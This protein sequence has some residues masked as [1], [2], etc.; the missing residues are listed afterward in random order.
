MEKKTKILIVD[1]DPDTLEVYAQIFGH[2]GY[3]VDVA[4]TAKEG[5]RLARECH[6]ALVLLDVILPDA[7]GI[8]VCQQIKSDPELAGT[9]VINLSAV[10]T[11]ST[12]QAD[13]LNAGADGYLTKPVAYEEL[14]ARV[15][16]LLRLGDGAETQVAERIERELDSLDKMAA[17]PRAA[18]TSRLYGVQPLRESSPK[19][20]D[21]MVRAY[22]NLL[23][24]A[25]EQRAYKVDHE[26]SDK[27]R[28]LVE[29]LGFLK[30]G[31]RDVV[32]IHSSALRKKVEAATPQMAQVYLEEGRV[33]VLECMG[34]LVS[35]YRM[36]SLGA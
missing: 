34:Y 12:F 25:L 27:L 14:V 28:A 33:R 23:E 15:R 4:G 10:Q 3:D 32:D 8:E 29:R 19:L 1:D 16:A 22:S 36:R 5:L 20:F 26:V 31:P 24:M 7:S 35:Y 2:E 6:P 9:F 18:I 17:P 11:S 21:D 13:A 30:A